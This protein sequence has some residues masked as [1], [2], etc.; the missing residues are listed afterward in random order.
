[1]SGMMVI[2]VW[3]IIDGWRIGGVGWLVGVC[4]GEWVGVLI[5]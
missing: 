3:C 5:S 4:V 1:M 2:G